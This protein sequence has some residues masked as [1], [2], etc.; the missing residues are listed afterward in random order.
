MTH[1]PVLLTEATGGLAIR[2]GARAIDGTFGGGGHTEAILRASAP[3]GRV[4]SIDRDDT[5][6]QLGGERLAGFGE[7]VVLRHGSFRDMAVLAGE[8]GFENVDAILLD[9]GISSN[10]LDDPERGFSFQANGPLDMRM[11]RQA[12]VSADVI[13]NEW[14]QDALADVIYKYGDEPRSRRIARAIVAA[15]PLTSTT[16]LADVVAKALG[17]QRGQRTHPAT[18]VFQALRIAVNDELGA[19]EAVL[20]QTVQLLAHGG[21]VAIITFHSLEDR[22]VKQFFQREERDCICDTLPGYVRTRV[23]QPCHCGHRASLRIV[24]RKP[25]RPGDAEVAGNVRS[26]SA[27]LRIAE[28]L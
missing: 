19:L 1:L 22:L 20:P 6:I 27:K 28:R 25:I 13:V 17:G 5:A 9:L 4:L 18:Q 11:D 21:R 16:E 3:D 24:T 23:P 26:R 8:T 14:A 10:Q 15:R 12:A 2:Q 7:R